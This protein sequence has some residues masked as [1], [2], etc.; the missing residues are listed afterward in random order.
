MPTNH[1]IP[2]PQAVAM[3][4]L[5]RAEKENILM[6]EY[7]GKNILLISETFDRAAF[8]TLLAQ[9]GCE[10]IRIYYGMEDGLKVRVLAVGVNEKD[11]DMLPSGDMAK[12]GGDKIVEVGQPCPEL[13]PPPSPLNP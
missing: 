10:K 5:Y 2:L 13:C 4:T 11:E 6:P 3:T 8:D 12:D 9:S 1:F 7:R